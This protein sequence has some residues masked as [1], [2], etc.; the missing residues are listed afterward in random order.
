MLSNTRNIKGQ[1]VNE[2]ELQK[3]VNSGALEQ[4]AE[5]GANAGLYEAANSGAIDQIKET[6]ASALAQIAASGLEEQKLP[7]SSKRWSN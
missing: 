2:Q 5:S 3:L 4:I 6:N 1:G 7:D